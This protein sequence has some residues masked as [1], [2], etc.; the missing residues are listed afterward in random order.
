MQSRWR[1]KVLWSSIITQVCA[2]LV[3]CGVLD[4]VTSEQVQAVLGTVLQLAVIV[5]IVNNPTDGTGW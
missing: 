3:M 1:S 2:I 4:S 5:G